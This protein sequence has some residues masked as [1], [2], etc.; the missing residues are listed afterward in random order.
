MFEGRIELDLS[1]NVA[2]NQACKC[3]VPCG[4]VTPTEVAWKK[5]IIVCWSAVEQQHTCIRNDKNCTDLPTTDYK[6]QV[7]IHR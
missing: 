5:R 7:V 3:L 4:G 6:R 2:K 1:A